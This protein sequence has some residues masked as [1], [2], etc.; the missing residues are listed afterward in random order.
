MKE[1]ILVFTE[2]SNM[3]IKR[4]LSFLISLSLICSA[5]S[6]IDLDNSLRRIKDDTKSEISSVLASK[7]DGSTM[8]S[9]SDAPV[10]GT[11]ADVTDSDTEREDKTK[12]NPNE[13]RQGSHGPSP[14]I[15]WHEIGETLTISSAIRDTEYTVE[16]AQL[17]A[18]IGASGLPQEDIDFALA[19]ASKHITDP[20][21]LLT[22]TVKSVRQDKTVK[23]DPAS[24]AFMV[25]TF[26][27]TEK[28]NIEEGKD[29]LIPEIVYFD[30]HGD[31]SKDEYGC[32]W[33]EE[34]EEL[35]L[36]IG[37]LCSEGL[38]PEDELVLRIKDIH[39][40]HKD[41]IVKLGKLPYE[42]PGTE[43]R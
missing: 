14:E 18:D 38:D 32:Y 10:S 40:D 1:W 30:H 13:Y 22:I 33:L 41:H 28:R 36:R 21:V 17:F 26:T 19:M 39:G 20:F 27:L 43:M 23:A 42:Q 6:V 15:V 25:G 11:K 16:L 7:K 2:N 3:K 9:D 29:I 35:T 37:I 31:E 8:G 4:Y 24:N 34:G 5:C 12:D